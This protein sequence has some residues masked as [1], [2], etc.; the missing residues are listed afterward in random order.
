MFF[1]WSRELIVGVW[2]LC[3]ADSEKSQFWWSRPPPP[4][5][6]VFCLFICSRKH[7]ELDVQSQILQ[8]LASLD[9]T[10]RN[11]PG[12]LT[13]LAAQPKK[14]KVKVF[15]A[16]GNYLEMMA[17]PLPSHPLAAP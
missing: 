4:A 12:Q 17:S 6:K 10:T 9:A 13:F 3:L 1:S 15:A 5:W 8:C 11:A 16:Q 14:H 7:N 2:I